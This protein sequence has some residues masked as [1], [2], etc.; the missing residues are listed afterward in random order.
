MGVTMQ[1]D[2]IPS[3]LL[4]ENPLIILPKLA[5]L[6]GLNQAIIIQ[7]LHYWLIRSD[8]VFEG[9]KWTYNTIKQWRKQFPFFGNNTIVRTF[10]NLNDKL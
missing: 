3:L 2:K 6:I 9:K 8:K 5:T 4:D 10:K 1:N 7:Q